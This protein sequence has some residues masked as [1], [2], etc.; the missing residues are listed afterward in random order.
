MNHSIC[1]ILCD[2]IF[3]RLSYLSYYFF[4]TVDTTKSDFHTEFFCII[5]CCFLFFTSCISSKQKSQTGT[6]WSWEPGTYAL[7]LQHSWWKVIW[8]L[9][10]FT[11][12]QI[13]NKFFNEKFFSGLVGVFSEPKSILNLL[14]DFLKD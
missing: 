12:L 11:F 1:V 3:C 9:L 13:L 5:W 14:Q 7:F 2:I 4:S 8:H 10:H 6:F